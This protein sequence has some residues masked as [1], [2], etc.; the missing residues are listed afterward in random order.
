MTLFA[1]IHRPYKEC[2]AEDTIAVLK[3]TLTDLN[4]APDEVFHANPYP[5]LY[6]CSLD[7]PAELGGFHSNGKGRNE[8]F[9]LASAYAEFAERLQ[10]GLY[11][12]F[13]RTMV[14]GFRERH[15]FYYAPDERYLSAAEFADLPPAAVADFV[16]YQG[17]GRD[18]FMARYHARVLE[19]GAPGVVAVPFYDTAH[20]RVVALPLNL[21]LLTVGS[22]GMAAGNTRPEA[23]YQALSELLERWGA[24]EVFFERLTP[25]T[26]PPDYLA[27]FEAEAAIIAAVEASGR[28]RV[29]VKDFSAGRRIPALGVIVENTRDHLY[30]LNVGS[31]TCFQVNL[32]RCLTEVYQGVPDADRFD[33]T[34]LPM[35]TEEPPC[36]QDDADTALFMRYAEFGQFTKDNRGQFPLALFGD[37]PD[38]VF[39][40]SVWEQR[41]SHVAEV[42]RLVG[43]FHDQ[44]HDVYLRDVTFLGFP[45][46]FAYVPEVSALGRKNV[47]PP[48]MAEDPLMLALDR[49]EEHLL[50]IGSCSA[51]GLRAV[52]DV[53]SQITSQVP[54]LDVA[55]VK[56]RNES[57]WAQLNVG[58]LLTLLWWRLGEVERARDAF[59]AFR[60]TR[61]DDENPYYDLAA[62]YLDRR[63]EGLDAEAAAE[64]L[65]ASP[66]ED[67]W[68]R[69]V[70]EDLRDPAD[71]FRHIPLPDCPDCASCALRPDCATTGKLAAM[72][73]LMPAM[74]ASVTDQ[75]ALSWSRPG[76]PR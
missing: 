21:L 5:G 1:S 33:A 60:M 11:A 10:N 49:V 18:A 34:A 30:R 47:P 70:A 39:D 36:F 20:N 24:A 68:A 22:N 3:K 65:A 56:V 53:L 66:D 44:G 15:G 6:S 13:S 76:V 63:V 16:R 75:A 40:P 48:V 7:L 28:Y 12:T 59:A 9:S 71:A 41:D 35:L 55:G 74:A 2:A 52:A 31:D 45:S 46:V 51:E 27:Q 4:L 14:A 64:G 26:V 69:I 73:R 23:V 61:P 8:E 32:S 43:F 67:E 19:N 72:D 57:A 42:R 17:A 54:F 25:P 38:Y 62:R 29:T 58:F 37:D 50:K